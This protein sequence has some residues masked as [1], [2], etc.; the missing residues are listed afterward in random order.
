[1]KMKLTMVLVTLSTLFLTACSS[2]SSSAADPSG[3]GS[4]DRQTI[5]DNLTNQINYMRDQGYNVTNQGAS[6]VEMQQLMAR[7]KANGCDK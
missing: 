2:T 5:C 1:M 3:V 6:Q 7:Y 4:Y